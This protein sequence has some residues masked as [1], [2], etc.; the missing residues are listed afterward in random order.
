MKPASSRFTQ[1]ID[2]P[3]SD[4]VLQNKTFK[5]TKNIKDGENQR[6]FAFMIYKRFDKNVS[7]F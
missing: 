1:K 7:Q 2:L 4:K 6:E 5:V 3:A